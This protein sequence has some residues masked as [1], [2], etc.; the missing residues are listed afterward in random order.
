VALKSFLKALPIREKLLTIIML[1][2]GVALILSAFGI[3]GSDSLLFR[4]YLER[5]IEALASITAE[6]TTAAISFDDPRSATDT[7]N[8]LHARPHLIAACIY[9]KNGI[10]LAQY[11]RSGARAACPRPETA[12]RSGFTSSELIDNHPIILKN[13]RIGTLT[14]SYDL[15]EIGERQRLYGG[16]V[17]GV[18]LTSSLIAFLLS[19]RLRDMI[20]T[21]ILDL[22]QTTATV[23]RTRDYSIRANKL[24]TDELGLLVETFNEMLAGIQHRDSELRNALISREDALIQA[25]SARDS[26]E[27]TLASIGDAV[28]STD[29]DGYILFA[30]RV[31]LGLLGRPDEDI[32]GQPL[33]RV[34]RIVNEFTRAPIENP[35][36]GV[37]A[38]GSASTLA[39]QTVLIAV[40]GS[41][42]PIEGSASPMR[43]DRGPV[44]GA[45]LVFRDV[46]SRRRASETSRLLA[47]IVES[48]GDAIIGSDLEGQISSWNLGA[49]RI[50]GYTAGEMIGRPLT[51][52][53]VPS[54]DDVQDILDRI[55]TGERIQ[56]YETL[57]RT[58]AG[59][60]INL[61][62]T[63]S[64]IYDALGRIVGAS[65]IARD[66]TGHVLA[67]QRLT[68]LNA[69][70]RDTN[71]DLARSN[72]DLERFAFVASH[73]L[74][75]PLRMITVYSQL[76]TRLYST[77]TDEKAA[78]YVNNIVG[79]THRMREL[80]ADL[81]AYTEVGAQLEQAP[82]AVDLNSVLEKAIDNLN[83]AIVNNQAQVTVDPMPTLRVYPAH[84][85][86]L[87]QN[88]IGNAIKYRGP[89]PPR[90]HVS[91]QAID[92]GVRFAVSDNG[93][94]IEPQ[95]HDKIF[96]AFKRL[97]GK[98]IPGTGIG[99]AICHRV[100]ERYGGKI[101][102]ESTLGHGSTF[103]FTL[104][105]ALGR[106]T[107]ARA[108]GGANGELNDSN[109]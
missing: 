60:T 109:V 3:M 35:L 26:L 96:V 95:Y 84:V 71:E 67:S 42:I 68:Q 86:S 20:A 100:V 80:L 36:T 32:A 39:G 83:V 40:D 90:V 47:S 85:L 88:L 15:A 99:L 25:H 101:W 51:L 12:E 65:K 31:A 50:F 14:M 27:T 78:T 76:L 48:S 81:L 102:V 59:N 72:E 37:L 5:D 43:R 55:A 41:E 24:S 1:V 94:G 105:A 16:T 62:L 56:N 89:E 91:V 75:E 2:C 74:Q 77:A 57:R 9:R 22:A 29:I 21:P 11:S 64:P 49:E 7:L 98:S 58:R 79:G 19:S 73:D 44:Q 52:L 17:L 87:F 45:V 30:N 6:N 69:D 61:S 46:T 103:F 4:S 34:F 104:P 53:T 66:I 10:L 106:V 107:S 23:S 54:H 28:I 108:A 38:D 63:V 70:L 92:D 93:M 13:A 33:D 8:A 18:L 82:E 97:H